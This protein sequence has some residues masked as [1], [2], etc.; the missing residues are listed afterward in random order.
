MRSG[1]EIRWKPR[2]KG[3]AKTNADNTSA[4]LKT[5][6]VRQ[7]VSASGSE[8]DANWPNLRFLFCAMHL[9][10]T[11]WREFPAQST[12][13]LRHYSVSNPQPD[14]RPRSHSISD[15]DALRE[16]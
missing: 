2:S 3:C 8:I 1:W 11:C 5:G 4:T 16:N 14:G 15:T 12:A 7:S 6:A 9:A 13:L 10:F